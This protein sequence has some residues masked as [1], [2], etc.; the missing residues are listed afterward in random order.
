MKS[1]AFDSGVK[2]LIGINLFANKTEQKNAWS[3]VPKYLDFNY[4]IFERNQNV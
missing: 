1:E 4:L 2:E 3:D